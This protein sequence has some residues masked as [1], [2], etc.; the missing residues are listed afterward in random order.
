MFGSRVSRSAYEVREIL[1]FYFALRWRSQFLGPV[2]LRKKSIIFFF[3]LNEVGKIEMNTSKSTSKT[4]DY[5]PGFLW[6][7]CICSQRPG[8]ASL[9]WVC[10]VLCS[11]LPSHTTLQCFCRCSAPHYSHTS[12]AAPGCQENC[13][14]SGLCEIKF[15]HYLG[16][17][18]SHVDKIPLSSL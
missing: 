14:L 7:S 10:P 15:S 16:R 1:Y 5:I 11:P 8:Q 6:L 4:S 12:L 18:L 13:L 2:L 3:F 17:E 9:T